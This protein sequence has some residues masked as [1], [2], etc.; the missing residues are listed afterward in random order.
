MNLERMRYAGRQLK[1][2]LALPCYFASLVLMATLFLPAESSSAQCTTKSNPN[3]NP[4]PESFDCGGRLQRRLQERH[5][6]AKQH[7][8]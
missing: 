7:H 2:A 8:R 5:S 3:L 4:N 6:V 1:L